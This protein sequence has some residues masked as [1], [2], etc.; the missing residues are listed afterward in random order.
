MRGSPA[1]RE[2]YTSIRCGKFTVSS[3][4]SGQFGA[5]NGFTTLAVTDDESIVFP[6]YTDKQVVNGVAVSPDQS[7]APQDL[8]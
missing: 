8:N 6:A 3:A 5:G 7:Y 1:N 2:S 4:W